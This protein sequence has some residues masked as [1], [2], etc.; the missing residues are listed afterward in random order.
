MCY[1]VG[2]I[3]LRLLSFL[4]DQATPLLDFSLLTCFNDTTISFCVV[5]FA[6]FSF[7]C[8]ILLSASWYR[9]TVSRLD[10][11]RESMLPLS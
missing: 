2:D 6:P 11:T 8:N 7:A 5:P 9:A 10:T 1:F 3:S 4:W